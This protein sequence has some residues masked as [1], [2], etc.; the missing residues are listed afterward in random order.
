MTITNFK[1][2]TILLDRYL[3]PS[4]IYY[5]LKIWRF[6]WKDYLSHWNLLVLRI[7]RFCLKDTL[8]HWH[9]L[10]FKNLKILLGYPSDIYYFLRI[11]RFC[12]KDTLS[13]L[14]LLFV[15]VW[16]FCW[17]DTWSHW[18]L[19]FLKNLNIVLERCNIPLTFIHIENLKIL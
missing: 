8:L 9:L 19:L 18:H 1:N 15:R 5:F 13:G 4:E 2:L 16:K 17:T 7:W 14:H 11:W 3:N 6:C 10:F 12:W